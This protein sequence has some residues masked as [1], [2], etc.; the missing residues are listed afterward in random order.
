[1]NRSD[2]RYRIIQDRFLLGKSAFISGYMPDSDADTLTQRCKRRV[3]GSEIEP[4]IMSQT[5]AACPVCQHAREEELARL[6][7]IKDAKRQSKTK[8]KG[9][10]RAH[11]WGSGSDSDSDTEEDGW[12]GGEPGL[13]KV[14]VGPSAHSAFLSLRRTGEPSADKYKTA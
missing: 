11:G 8:A 2:E 1:M 3:P 4:F 6:A 5:V 12:G 9:K 14:C 7:A 13:M 10:G